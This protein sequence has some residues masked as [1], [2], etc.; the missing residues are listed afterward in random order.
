MQ[1]RRCVHWEES[2]GRRCRSGKM[3]GNLPSLVAGEER[4][5]VLT[6]NV[7]ISTPYFLPCEL[8]SWV[9]LEMA[10]SLATSKNKH[11]AE[12]L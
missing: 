1:A 6:S 12:S 4:G 8:R 9:A 7:G 3:T 10:Q 11:A 2:A 5:W